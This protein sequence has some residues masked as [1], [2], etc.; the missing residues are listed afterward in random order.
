M[1]PCHPVPF[2]T[3]YPILAAASADGFFISGTD[4]TNDW[5]KVLKVSD[6]CSIN[7]GISDLNIINNQKKEVIDYKVNLKHCKTIQCKTYLTQ[8]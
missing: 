1:T 5:R 4:K 6:L 3:V 8:A 7:Q 2:S